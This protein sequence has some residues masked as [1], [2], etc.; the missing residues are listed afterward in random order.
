M[1]DYTPAQLANFDQ[2]D[3][4]SRT[5]ASKLIG[6]IFALNLYVE[7]GEGTQDHADGVAYL[8]HEAMS[9]LTREQLH[10][11]VL[12]LCQRIVISLAVNSGD[13]S[14]IKVKELLDKGISVMGFTTNPERASSPFPTEG[15]S[16]Q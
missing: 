13:G 8:C 3:A 9:E 4:T 5:A 12:N 2:A 11:L 6:F 1:T 14:L 15:H 16:G 7:T 10:L